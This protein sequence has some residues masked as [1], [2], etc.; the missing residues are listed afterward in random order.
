MYAIR[1][2]YVKAG[3][4]ATIDDIKSNIDYVNKAL[5]NIVKMSQK[6]NCCAIRNYNVCAETFSNVF[7]QLASKYSYLFNTEKYP[8]IDDENLTVENF[9]EKSQ[10]NIDVLKN[11]SIN[12]RNNF[13]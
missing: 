5:N 3:D 9:I 6:D 4:Y 8:V 2:Y 13:V 12:L 1:S 7:P 11:R 10:K